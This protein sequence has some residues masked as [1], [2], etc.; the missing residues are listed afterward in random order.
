MKVVRLKKIVRF[1]QTTDELG[2][3][4]R[5]PLLTEVEKLVEEPLRF[6]LKR[7]AINI[8]G[9]LLD[10]ADGLVS[11]F[12]KEP[13]EKIYTRDKVFDL[14]TSSWDE[15]GGLE[16]Q[17]KLLFTRVLESLHE[18]TF[19]Y[20]MEAADYLSS[21]DIEDLVKWVLRAIQD[22]LA[23]RLTLLRVRHRRLL[24]TASP[25]S[26]LIAVGNISDLKPQERVQLERAC[27]VKELWW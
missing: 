13:E 15:R 19:G 3:S 12:R 7:R 8:A 20:L 6:Q 27:R 24:L 9:A 14:L 11:R 17:D 5:A 26:E 10:A 22:I 23:H 16:P 2:K 18:D 25:M 1:I 21:D 4:Q